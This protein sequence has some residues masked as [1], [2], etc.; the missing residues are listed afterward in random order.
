[1][2]TKCALS[3][4]PCKHIRCVTAFAFSTVLSQKLT[5]ACSASGVALKSSHSHTVHVEC[6]ILNQLCPNLPNLLQV[7]SIASQLDISL[8][9]LRLFAILS[10][11]GNGTTAFAVISH[12]QQL[13]C[14]TRHHL[15]PAFT[16]VHG[17]QPQDA[18]T[19][20]CPTHTDHIVG[21]FVIIL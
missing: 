17:P 4:Q 3:K 11:Q 16:K 5:A 20:S 15:L 21:N 18:L 7:P 13:A 19:R 6:Q 9:C 8:L 2:F 10:R 14:L 1:M 12:V